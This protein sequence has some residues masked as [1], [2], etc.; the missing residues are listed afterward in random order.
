MYRLLTILAFSDSAGFATKTIH[1][2]IQER[3]TPAHDEFVPTPVRGVDE[4]DG[5]LE[6][7]QH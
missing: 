3:T 5:V 2:E 6:A 7:I 1:L 4:S